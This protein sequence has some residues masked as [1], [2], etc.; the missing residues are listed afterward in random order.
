M[1]FTAPW[2]YSSPIFLGRLNQRRTGKVG[3]MEVQEKY[4]IF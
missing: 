1:N 3:R 4:R 2:S